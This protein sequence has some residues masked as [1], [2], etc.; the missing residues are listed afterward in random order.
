MLLDLYKRH[1]VRILLSLVILVF[2]LLHV[3]GWD[4]F[5]ISALDGLELFAYD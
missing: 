5:R 2:F 3:S 4:I 1:L